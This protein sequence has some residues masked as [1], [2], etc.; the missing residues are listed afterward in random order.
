[1][2]IF[3]RKYVCVFFYNKGHDNILYFN[4]QFFPKK[5]MVK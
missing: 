1:M 3:R 5:K 2:S 4:E